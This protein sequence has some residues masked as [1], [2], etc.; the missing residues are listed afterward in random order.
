LASAACFGASADPVAG[1]FGAS[2]GLGHHGSAVED[3]P[4]ASFDTVVILMYRGRC[5]KTLIFL[6]FGAA[7][8]AE[9]AI[10]LFF[11]WFHEGQ[12]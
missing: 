4:S 11:P 5:V 8:M 7:D 12:L 1:T 10:F 9:I 6:P 2:A 3:V